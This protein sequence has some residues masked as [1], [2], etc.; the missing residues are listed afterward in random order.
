MWPNMEPRGSPQQIDAGEEDTLS[1]I[2]TLNPLNADNGMVNCV[3]RDLKDF[4]SVLS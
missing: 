4:K 1:H 3:K 2:N